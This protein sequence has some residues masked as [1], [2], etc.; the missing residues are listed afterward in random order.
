MHKVDDDQLLRSILVDDVVATLTIVEKIVIGEFAGYKNSA[1]STVRRF[2][3]SQS[4]KA[5][6]ELLL[7]GQRLI[8]AELGDSPFRNLR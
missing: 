3:G 1:G 8:E 7:V 5:F 6:D 2:A 4:A